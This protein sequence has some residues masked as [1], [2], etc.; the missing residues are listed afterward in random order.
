M[1]E[2]GDARTPDVVDAERFL[3]MSRQDAKRAV[4]ISSDAAYERAYRDI[5]AAVSTRN[6]RE[7]Q[8]GVRATIVIKRRGVQIQDV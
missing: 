5:E 2:Q 8:G 7:G 1:S 4:G 3:S 6:N